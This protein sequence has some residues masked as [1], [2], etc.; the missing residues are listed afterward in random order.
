MQDDKERPAGTGAGDPERK[1]PL[2][3]IVKS[4]LAAGFGVQSGRN[5]E[6]DFT[7][8]QSRHYI[9]G[10]IIFTVLFVATVF[11]VVKIVLRQAGMD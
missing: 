7:Q 4:I 9:I 1:L 6:R 11:T 2:G 3:A 8:G 10:G 5:R